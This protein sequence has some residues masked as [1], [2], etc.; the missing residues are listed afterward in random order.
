MEVHRN[1]KITIALLLEKEGEFSN[2]AS[3]TQAVIGH[4][5]LVLRSLE[6]WSMR[7][8]LYL[9]KFDRS[10]THQETLPI[11]KSRSGWRCC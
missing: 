7:F 1:G 2:A 3:E 6:S 10:D 4:D 5:F 11:E 9:F 8:I